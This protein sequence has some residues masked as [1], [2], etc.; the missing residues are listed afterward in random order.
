[1]V[2][3]FFFCNN[4]FQNT[5]VYQPTLNTLD[6]KEDKGTDHVIGWKLEGVYTSKLKP[7]Y[8]AF[9]HS[10][11]LSGYRIGTQFDNNLAVEQT[12]VRPKLKI[13]TLSMI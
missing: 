6:L 7:L 1:M 11:K 3:F 10:I 4:G 9:L 5:F 8:A 2:I 12:I 13:L